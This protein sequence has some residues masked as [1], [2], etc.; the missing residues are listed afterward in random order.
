MLALMRFRRKLRIWRPTISGLYVAAGIIG[1]AALG[2][3]RADAG[4][5]DERHAGG[6]PVLGVI[7]Q[8]GLIGYW[9]FDGDGSDLSGKG[10]NLNLFG[11]AGF[12]E[13]TTD[14]RRR[15][16]CF[17]PYVTAGVRNCH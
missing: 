5:P 16:V 15:S 7:D 13:P 10:R 14:G 8:T 4:S 12:A 3:D 17:P 9:P 6:G 2:P 1:L 11:G